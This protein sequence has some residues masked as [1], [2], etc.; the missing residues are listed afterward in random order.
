MQF[1]NYSSLTTKLSH[2][3]PI[4]SF[5][6][7]SFSRNSPSPKSSALTYK[8][9]STKLIQL[10]ILSIEIYWLS[11][12]QLDPVLS[13]QNTMVRISSLQDFIFFLFLHVFFCSAN[14]Y[15]T[16]TL[17][18]GKY[19]ELKNR[20]SQPWIAIPRRREKCKWI[21][22]NLYESA[23]MIKVL[24]RKLWMIDRHGGSRKG[25][26]LLRVLLKISNKNQLSWFEFP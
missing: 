19:W 1:F 24:H 13:A 2:P 7:C 26:A 18:Q 21:F 25:S 5:C 17:H 15:W 10:L 12:Y 8:Q 23:I 9:V 16:S 14:I 20:R 3:I 6:L 4:F 22:S 11:F